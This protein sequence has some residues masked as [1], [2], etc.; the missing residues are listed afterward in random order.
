MALEVAPF[1][2]NGGRYKN[3]SDWLAYC[4]RAEASNWPSAA[5]V[6]AREREMCFVWPAVVLS[7]FCLVLFFIG[8]NVYKSGEFSPKVTDFWLLKKT[9]R[10]DVPCRVGPE[11]GRLLQAGPGCS[12]HQIGPTNPLPS[13]TA[14]WSCRH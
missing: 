2:S 8:A 10:A 5:W 11:S 12:S 4:P 7:C 3:W 13:A 9:G 14:C 6:W 1:Y